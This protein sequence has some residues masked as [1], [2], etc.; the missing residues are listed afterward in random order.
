MEQDMQMLF[1]HSNNRTL[2]VIVIFIILTYA[3]NISL[4]LRMTNLCKLTFMV[5]G[6]VKRA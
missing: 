2:I 6:S 4:F 3:Q 5:D 1:Y